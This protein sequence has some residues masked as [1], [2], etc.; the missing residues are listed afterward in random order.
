MAEN[1][2]I[3]K[4]ASIGD[5]LTKYPEVIEIFSKYGFHCL[6]CAASS[7]ESIEEGASAHN[8]DIDKFMGDLNQAISKKE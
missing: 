5:T 3:T 4:E 1:E 7:F 8:I 6:G 2:I